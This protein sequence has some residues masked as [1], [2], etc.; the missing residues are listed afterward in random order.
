MGLEFVEFKLGLANKVRGQLQIR[1]IM[2]FFFF[3]I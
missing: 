1:A 3:K 2:V